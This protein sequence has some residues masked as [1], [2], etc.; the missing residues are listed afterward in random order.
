[1]I[2]IGAKGHALD[3][4]AKHEFDDLIVFDNISKSVPDWL[5]E[6]FIVIRSFD[7][8]ANQLEICPDYIIATG[9]PVIRKFLLEQVDSIGGKVQSFISP[10]A[11]VG[12]L[13]VILSDGLN[14]MH[15]CTI[16][17]NVIIGKGSLIN[18]YASIHHDVEIGSFTEVS[19]GARILGRVKIGDY[20]SIGANA[21]V[22]PDISIGSNVIVGAGAI[23]TNNIG[24]NEIVAGVP[25]V[26]LK[27]NKSIE[28]ELSML[29]KK[30]N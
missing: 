4:L 19:P 11:T 25:A 18:S 20:S 13:N 22:L 30:Y 9:T 8:L 15:Y 26:K 6:N 23:V 1:M 21:V 16:S 5:V 7:A 12:E 3:I 28:N 24:D 10:V 29:R 2:L 17:N 14:I 27:E